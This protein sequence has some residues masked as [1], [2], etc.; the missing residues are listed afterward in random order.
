MITEN[1]QVEHLTDDGE[2]ATEFYKAAVTGF[3]LS[4]NSANLSN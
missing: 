4:N 2:I 1:E 3:S